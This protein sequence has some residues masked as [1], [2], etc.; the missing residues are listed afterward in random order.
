M[1]REKAKRDS[2]DDSGSKCFHCGGRLVRERSYGAID[3]FRC[4]VCGREEAIHSSP[5]VEEVYR[6]LGPTGTLKVMWRSAEPTVRDALALRQLVEDFRDLPIGDVL[7]RIKGRSGWVFE[8]LTLRKAEELKRQALLLG[9][10][11]V[12]ELKE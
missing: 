5:P 8:R 7:R 2:A 10:R 12:F 3:F 11:S 1:S 4:L 6:A 9:F